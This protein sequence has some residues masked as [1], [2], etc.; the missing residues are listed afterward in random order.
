MKPI[1]TT[2]AALLLA[3]LMAASGALAG[4]P[5][6]ASRY[7]INGGEVYDKKTDLTWARCSVGQRWKE[8]IGCAGVIKQFTWSEAQQQASGEWRVPN[9]DE[10][11]TLIDYPRKAQHQ[12]PTIDED[13]FPDMDLGKLG[14]WSSTPDGAS[15]AWL[16]SFGFGDVLNGNY[17][18]GRIG[19]Y[20][21]RLVRG[22]Q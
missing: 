4:S 19:P 8:G 3:L 1:K 6:K 13:A 12:K 5:A 22:G 20:S 2:R 7:V 9:K 16:V 18:G 10:L 14:Y 21:V 11:A 15:A 17:Y